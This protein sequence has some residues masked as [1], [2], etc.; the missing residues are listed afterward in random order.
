[1]TLRKTWNCLAALPICL[2]SAMFTTSA[3]ATDGPPARD[4]KEYG[5]TLVTEYDVSAEIIEKF[6][7]FQP[8]SPNKGESALMNT[9]LANTQDWFGPF[10]HVNASQNPYRV[11]VTLSGYAK[12]DG[13]AVTMWQGGW[14]LDDGMTRR[15][16]IAGL[17]KSD[18]RAG[19]KLVLTAASSPNSFAKD[20]EVSPSLGLIKAQNMDIKSVHVQ[21]WSGVASVSPVQAI[22]SMPWFIVAVVFGFLTWRWRRR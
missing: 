12:A 14:R 10:F 8:S 5:Q 6:N 21:V 3:S 9:L 18:V 20:M 22:L 2:G 4:S 7:S 1:M 11:V 15:T 19:E 16:V 17:T 13:D